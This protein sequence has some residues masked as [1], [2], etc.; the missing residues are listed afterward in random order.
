MDLTPY[1]NCL[2]LTNSIFIA[3]EEKPYRPCCWFREYIDATDIA[4][5]RKQLSEMDIEKTCDYCIKQ[6]KGGEYSYRQHF[7]HED[8]ISVTVSFDNICNLKCITCTPSNS[9]LIIPDMYA[10]LSNPENVTARKFYATIG[11][12]A[13][14][15]ISFLKDMLNNIDFT[16]HRL[17]FSILGGEPLIN[18]AIFEFLDWLVEQPYAHKTLLS[19]TTNGTTYNEKLLKYIERF[20]IVGV[21]LSID[22][23]EDDFEYIRS[24]ANFKQ[25]E[26][27]CDSF[28]ELKQKYSNF[29]MGCH[30]T[31]SWMNCLKFAD[32]YNW[33]HS[34]YPNLTDI[35]VSKL[36]Q[37][38]HYSIEILSLEMRTKIYNEVISKLTVSE[39]QGFKNGLFLYKEH[40]LSTAFDTFDLVKFKYGV[41]IMKYILDERRGTDSTNIV[42]DFT[43]FT[44]IEI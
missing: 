36:E 18:P 39:H 19:V 34:R 35:Y 33:M 14:K 26:K 3:N 28:Y 25:L 37:P 7:K 24:G 20:N 41:S 6:D 32:F 11:K 17:N 30:Y 38:D 12:Q 29:N 4:D 42:N 15:K 40:M 27:V 5:Y 16:N 31:L 10:D 1:K 9:S 44:G 43:K 21:Q 23:V 2:A 13:P 22:G 8:E